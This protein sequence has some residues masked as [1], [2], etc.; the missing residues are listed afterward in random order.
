MVSPVTGRPVTVP[1]TVVW[2]EEALEEV[3]QVLL[4]TG[5]EL[6][7]CETGRRV[8]DEEVAESVATTSAESDD[9]LGEVGYEIFFYV[10]LDQLGVHLA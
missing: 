3:A 7:H 9:S 10:E 1:V 2:G 5:S 4:G 8:G 6:D